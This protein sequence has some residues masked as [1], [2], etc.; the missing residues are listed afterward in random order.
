MI[1]SQA[2]PSDSTDSATSLDPL[3]G[4]HSL[5]QELVKTHTDFSQGVLRQTGNPLDVGLEGQGFFVVDT[6]QGV[7]YTRQGAFSINADGV[8]VTRDGFAVQGEGG[9]LQV[10]GGR[11]TID[12]AGRVEVGG[13][14]RGRLK[15]V[16][17]SQP[18]DLEKMGHT[19]FRAKN[20]DLKEERPVDLLVHQESVEASNSEPLQLL[21]EMIVATRA[22][23]AYQKVIQ[24]FDE[25]A[26]RSVN[27][28]ARVV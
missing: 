1:V 10:N 12:A 16:N 19:L 17:F 7:A 18:N 8:L 4:V 22:F 20:P 6:P 27:D 23:E 14:E 2:Q 26:E 24:A 25:T 15:L 21:S 28:L 5:Q 9:P 11:V 3:R 13:V